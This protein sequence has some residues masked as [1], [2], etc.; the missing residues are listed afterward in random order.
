MSFQFIGVGILTLLVVF[1]GVLILG[2]LVRT[3]Q[4]D[5]LLR[6]VDGIGVQQGAVGSQAPAFLM[7]DPRTG[8]DISLDQL[9][10]RSG[11]LLFLSGECGACQTLAQ[12][13]SISTERPPLLVMWHGPNNDK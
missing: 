4:I 5:E 1:H 11:L 10:R 12:E 3:Q 2:L 7:T 8:R 13:L 6:S 9:G